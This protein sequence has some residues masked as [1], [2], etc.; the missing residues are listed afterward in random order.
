MVEFRRGETTQIRSVKIGLQAC[1]VVSLMA[2]V[3]A[4]VWQIFVACSVKEELLVSIWN[5]IRELQKQAFS[6]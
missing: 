1:V 6:I 3:P 2:T 5:S 4:A